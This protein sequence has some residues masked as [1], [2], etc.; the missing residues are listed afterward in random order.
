[1]AP[2]QSI[3]A[4]C[5]GLPRGVMEQNWAIFRG[6]VRAFWLDVPVLLAAGYGAGPIHLLLRCSIYRG[7]IGD[8]S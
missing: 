2:Y 7:R 6:L 8:R 4:A 5:V 3:T 1:M